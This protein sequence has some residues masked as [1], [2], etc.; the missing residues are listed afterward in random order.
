MPRGAGGAAALRW[1]PGHK[2]ITGNELADKLA[3]EAAATPCINPTMT[4]AGA[5]RWA[6]QQAVK[7]FKDWWENLVVGSPRAGGANPRRGRGAGAR[8]SELPL[9]R[10]APPPK[11]PRTVLATLLAAR[12]GHGDFT[13]YHIRF[14]PLGDFEAHCRCG[15]L[16]TPLYFWS[17]TKNSQR[18]LMRWWGNRIMTLEELVTTDA[19]A[20]CLAAW[21]AA[22]AQARAMN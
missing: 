14:H 4:M 15:A 22:V 10:G 9:P 7:D 19:G 20:Q 8:A 2:G 13:A 17:C 6:R 3:G 21:A 5:A 18:H 1:V 11:I 12:S 16:K